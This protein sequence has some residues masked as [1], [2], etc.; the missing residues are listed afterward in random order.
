MAV[1]VIERGKT[2]LVVPHQAAALLQRLMALEAGVHVLVV[3]KTAAGAA[4]FECWSVQSGKAE[5]AQK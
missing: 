4:G 1:D 3:I 2:A 5:T